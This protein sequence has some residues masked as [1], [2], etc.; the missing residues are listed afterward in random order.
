MA[1]LM[2]TIV[3]TSFDHSGFKIHCLDESADTRT[4]ALYMLTA[5]VA[6]AGTMMMGMPPLPLSGFV[7]VLRAHIAG[8]SHD[9]AAV[10][11]ARG[12]LFERRAKESHPD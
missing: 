1:R 11:H 12:S 2:I 7:G 5:A 9:V 6:A 10:R 4:F 8:V 3:V